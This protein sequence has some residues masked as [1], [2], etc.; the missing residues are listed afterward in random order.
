MS[1][2]ELG[3]GLGN[4]LAIQKPTKSQVVSAEK[5][6]ISPR[7]LVFAH[8]ISGNGP[9]L[10]RVNLDTGVVT[11]LSG[12]LPAGW[13][14]AVCPN[15][16]GSVLYNLISGSGLLERRSLQTGELL[17]SHTIPTSAYAIYVGLNASGD[18][19][20]TQDGKV[21]SGLESSPVLVKSYQAGVFGRPAFSQSKSIFAVTVSR[22]YERFAEVYDANTFDLLS[23]VKLNT[24]SV[25]DS[26]IGQSP[27]LNEDSSKALFYSELNGTSGVNAMKS[28]I[29]DLVSNSILLGWPNGFYGGSWFHVKAGDFGQNKAGWLTHGTDGHASVIQTNSTFIA[30]DDLVYR[31][32]FVNLAGYSRFGDFSVQL[33]RNP[34][35]VFRL[36][37]WPLCPGSVIKSHGLNSLYSFSQFY[38]VGDVDNVAPP[39]AV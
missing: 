9:F 10:G 18:F 21:F 22:G 31:N 29:L 24:S 26:W 12:T 2:R 11:D 7:N 8:G 16:T 14:G 28:Y 38:V 1:V 5:K 17:S 33:A 13:V 15:W 6:K 27:V 3:N 36:T 30:E 23:S 34:N 20:L 25:S 37:D 19:I 39:L 32:G 35:I 4:H